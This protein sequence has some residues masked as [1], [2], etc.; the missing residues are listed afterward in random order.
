[1]TR[2]AWSTALA[3]PL[4]LLAGC[5]VGPDFKSPAAPGTDTRV[6]VEPLPAATASANVPGG[7]AQ[8]FLANT[9]VAARWWEQ[10]QSPQL[11]A[12][13]NEALKNSPSIASAQAALRSAR[14]NAR[15]RW[16]DQFPEVDASFSATRQQ[17]DLGAFGN[18][19]GGS[20]IYNFF[21]ASVGVSY[22][23]DIW[24]GTRRGV[25]AAAAAAEARQYE[26]VAAYQTLI[27][28]VVASTVDMAEAAYLVEGENILIAD[29]TRRLDVIRKQFDAGAVS[30]ADVAVVAAALAGEKAKLY[31]YQNQLTRARTQLAVYLGRTPDAA[32]A[33]DIVLL[34][35]KLPL[36]I[37][38][39]LPSEIVR[40][41]PDL[42][43]AEAGLHEAAAKIGVATANQFPQ[44]ALT[45]SLGTQATTLSDLFKGNVWAIGGSITQPLFR[46]GELSALKKAA[47][48][49]YDKAEAD[50]RLT[51]LNAF[52]NV[53][54]SLTA[55]QSNASALAA[56]DDVAR[57]SE[58]SYNNAVKL[59]E[60][61]SGTLTEKVRL[62][63]AYTTAK[64]GY[65]TTVATR[66]RDTAALYMALG[67]NWDT[68]VKADIPSPP[69]AIPGTVAAA[70]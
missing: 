68:E 59:H 24:G 33:S 69:P 57:A 8:I 17:I 12:L 23:L 51:V 55:L 15:A 37:P 18:P 52:K 21:N 50:Y 1:M 41:R 43:A 25:E 65:A 47:I 46:A 10:Y 63:A 13:V 39:S 4:A 67:G 11:N 28:N 19:G 22:G 9:P 42:R 44:I 45:A 32:T 61:G 30:R 66:L 14:A 36:Q 6:S 53:S 60:L 58:V 62:H 34:D 26:L 38:V 64:V 20:L 31:G 27:A 54:D 7:E 49:D 29:E 2:T 48:A 16:S 3:L 40:Q 35:L 70:N 56:Y 5:A